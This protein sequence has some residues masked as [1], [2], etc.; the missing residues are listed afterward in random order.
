MSAY[1][2][3]DEFDLERRV[4]MT[5]EIPPYDMYTSLHSTM[6]NSFWEWI[7]GTVKVGYDYPYLVYDASSQSLIHNTDSE[8]VY[9]KMTNGQ[10]SSNYGPQTSTDTY[11]RLEIDGVLEPEFDLFLHEIYRYTETLYPDHPDERYLLTDTEFNDTILAAADMINYQP[12]VKFF[13][14]VAESLS[15]SLT[16]SEIKDEAAKLKIHNLLNEAFRRKLYGSKAGYRMLANDI[17]QMCT[18]FPV[19]TYL[20]LKEI[21]KERI[22]LE[23]KTA[24]SVDAL[25]TLNM[26]K[27]EYIKYVRQN[28][29][30]IDTYSSLYYRKFRLVD[31]DGQSSSYL[32]KED[33]NT[34][35]YGFSIPCEENRIFE[36][37]NSPNSSGSEIESVVTG[38]FFS[39][40]KDVKD[41]TYVNATSYNDT[42]ITEVR[43]NN[44]TDNG[45]TIYYGSESTSSTNAVNYI[46][47]SHLNWIQ[48]I[49][50]YIYDNVE[51][52]FNKFT[53]DSSLKTLADAYDGRYL[54]NT[55]L[56]DNNYF[57]LIFKNLATIDTDG[58]ILGNVT[59]D[60]LNVLLN[61]YADDT[62][63]LEPSKSMSFYP[64]DINIENPGT[65][66]KVRQDEIID[67]YNVFDKELCNSDIINNT[68]ET[69][70]YLYYIS[71]FTKGKISYSVSSIGGLFAKE[72]QFWGDARYGIVVNTKNN[73]KVVLLGKL[74]PKYGTSSGQLYI[75][76]ATIDITAI[77]E[78]KTDA[79]LVASYSDA[80]SNL[81]NIKDC[82]IAEEKYVSKGVGMTY[83]GCEDIIAL[84][85]S[86]TES[87]E[88]ERIYNDKV[89]E[90]AY[91]AIQRYINEVADSLEVHTKL[92]ITCDNKEY[93]FFKTSETNE[94]DENIIALG[95]K[96]VTELDKAVELYKK[97]SGKDY[98]ILISYY[99]SRKASEE[100]IETY[101]QNRSLMFETA[102]K[103]SDGSSYEIS[104]IQPGC[105]VSY[106]M[107]AYY[108][109]DAISYSDDVNFNEGIIDSF[110]LGCL[111]VFPLIN[112][113]VEV[114]KPYEFDADAAVNKQRVLNDDFCV[115]F[116]KKF[117]SSS[118]DIY[119]LKGYYYDHSINNH[120][121]S[122][123]YSGVDYVTLTNNNSLA[124]SIISGTY[125]STA[126]DA[127]DYFASYDGTT[128]DPTNIT[129]EPISTTNV[130]IEGVVDIETEGLERTVTF[131]SDLAKERC[132]SLSIGDTIYG[133]S[134]DTDDNDIYITSVGDNYVV[135][136]HD[137]QQS[138]TFVFTFK[139]KLNIVSE[140]ITDDILN[141]KE[142]L[143][144]NGLYSIINP[145]K[146]GL[147]GS[148]DFPNVS[149][150][151]LESLPDIIFYQPYNYITPL[152]LSSF[153]E[154]MHKIHPLY[155]EDND[156]SLPSTIKFNNDLFVELNLN[157]YMNQATKTSVSPSLITVDWL[158]Y[159]T[160]MLNTISRATDKVNIGIN[161]MMETDSTGYYTLD[162]DL[163]Y[164]D[165]NVR[166][167]FI[168]L[169]LDGMDMWNNYPIDT[170]ND[171]TVP[172]YAQIGTG[173]SGRATWF[174]SPADI[175]YPTIWGNSVYDS[176]NITNEDYENI[177]VNNGKLKRRSIWGKDS[178]ENKEYINDSRYSSVEK[179][180]FEIPLGEYDIQTRYLPT[181]TTDI[182]LASTTVQ[183][184]FFQETFNNLTKY[185]ED[186]DRDI[187]GQPIIVNKNDYINSDPIN[188]IS[189]FTSI[190]YLGEWV[191][192]KYIDDNGYYQIYYPIGK[193]NGDYY[194]INNNITLNDIGENLDSITFTDHTILLYENNK[195]TLYTFK[196]GSLYGNLN[197]ISNE[198]TIT[199]TY[200]NTTR[201]NLKLSFI[202]S[203]LYR[204]IEEFD[205]TDIL[206]IPVAAS[207]IQNF[208]F[209]KDKSNYLGN[210]ILW[211]INV[212]T[213]LYGTEIPL[214]LINNKEGQ[215]ENS[216]D[217]S[218]KEKITLNEGDIF[219][220]IIPADDYT[221]NENTYEYSFNNDL[222]IIKFNRCYFTNTLNIISN[223]II[224]DNE[225]SYLY[226]GKYSTLTGESNNLSNGLTKITLPRKF[227]TNGSY[228]F[229][230][231]I[232]PQFTA[233]GYEYT[234]SESNAVGEEGYDIIEN[235]NFDIVDKSHEV[236]FNVTR[237]AIYKDE[238]NDEFYVYTDTIDGE[239][240]DTSEKLKKVAIKFAEQKYFKNTIYITGA[241]QV[242]EDMQS[243]DESVTKN[244]YMNAIAGITEFQASYLAANDRILKI[245]PMSLRSIYNRYLESIFFSN[246]KNYDAEILGI[247]QN[248]NLVLSYDHDGDDATF[249][250]MNFALN[251]KQYAPANKYFDS[252]SEKYVTEA[253]NDTYYNFTDN[254]KFIAPTVRFNKV[255]KSMFADN[256]AEDE[257]TEFKYFKNLLMARVTVSLTN[258]NVIYQADNDSGQFQTLIK[259]IRTGDT[260]QDGITI[261][262]DIDKETLSQIDLINAQTSSPV[263]VSYVAYDEESK[264]FMAI[265]N[266]G[267][268]Y[269][270]SNV[271]LS[272]ASQV[273]LTE[274]FIDGLGTGSSTGYKTDGLSIDKSDSTNPIW[275]I[276][277]TDENNTNSM[278]Y[279]IPFNYSLNS[280]GH[281]TAN[282]LFGEQQNLNG[283]S[284]S[285]SDIINIGSYTSL[286]FD[287]ND[288]TSPGVAT[289]NKYVLAKDYAISEITGSAGN[290][291]YKNKPYINTDYSKFDSLPQTF[292]AK[293]T[294]SE[295]AVFVSDR[296]I[297]IRSP[298]YYCDASGNYTSDVSTEFF[299]KKTTAPITRDGLQGLILNK[300]RGYGES[301]GYDYVYTRW[302][303]FYTNW[304]FLFS[305]DLTADANKNLESAITNP[306]GGF[307]TE[308]NL[309]SNIDEGTYIAWKDDII[310]TLGTN[311]TYSYVKQLQALIKRA[312]AILPVSWTKIKSA[313]ISAKSHLNT[314]YYIYATY[315][316]STVTETVSNSTPS[317][318]DYLS[319]TYNGSQYNIN[320]YG[321]GKLASTSYVNL[322]D[323][324]VEVPL[325]YNVNA[326]MSKTTP[327]ASWSTTS[328][329]DSDWYAE[330]LYLLDSYAY[331]DV[332]F[333][334]LFKEKIYRVLFTDDSI[335]F[336][337]NDWSIITL[338][339]SDTYKVETINDIDNWNVVG[340]N[341]YYSYT[342]PDF[343]GTKM[344]IYKT[345]KYGTGTNDEMSVKVISINEHPKIF[346]IEATYCDSSVMILG[347][348]LKSISTIEHEYET[349][350]G[351]ELSEEGYQNKLKDNKYY[352]FFENSIYP[353]VMYSIDNGVTFNISVID[354]ELPNCSLVKDGNKQ[355]Y[356]SANQYRAAYKEP[357]NG[358]GAKVSGIHYVDGK[359]KLHL[360]DGDGNEFGYQLYPKENS[361]TGSLEWSTLEYEEVDTTE[362][363]VTSSY[364]ELYSNFEL[365]IFSNSTYVNRAS[366][367]GLN[368]GDNSVTKC[369]DNAITMSR[370][371][372]NKQTSGGSIQ[373]LVTFKTG[374]SISLAT[375][376][377]VI[378]KFSLSEYMDVGVPKLEIIT[379]VDNYST[380][381][382]MYNYRETLTDIERKNIST[383]YR[384][385][386]EDT[387]HTY[388]KYS[389]ASDS[390]GNLSY[391]L[392]E[393]KNS[394]NNNINLCDIDGN[395]IYNSG[396]ELYTYD[397]DD[398]LASS[399]DPNVLP[400]AGQTT[401]PSVEAAENDSSL[402][403]EDTDFKAF[404][405]TT[406]NEMNFTNT[407][408]NYF[409]IFGLD[410]KVSIKSGDYITSTPITVNGVE[411][412]ELEVKSSISSE[413]TLVSEKETDSITSLP[414]FD[415]SKK[416][417]VKYTG[418]ERIL[419]DPSVKIGISSISDYT[420]YLYSESD[421]DELKAIL[422]STDDIQTMIPYR[423]FETRF[424][425]VKINGTNYFYDKKMGVLPF[426][427]RR[428]IN[429]DIYTDYALESEQAIYTN[430]G[431]NE[432]TNSSAFRSP[433]TGI[434]IPQNGYG[435]LRGRTESNNSWSDELPWDLDPIAFENSYLKNAVGDY[436]KICNNA[437]IALDSNNGETL[438]TKSNTYEIYYKDILPGKSKTIKIYKFNNNNENDISSIS[439]Y[440]PIKATGKIWSS[441]DT[442]YINYNLASGE[443]QKLANIKFVIPS[444][445]R[446]ED[447]AEYTI[448]VSIDGKNY[449]NFVDDN[450]DNILSIKNGILLYTTPESTIDRPNY[451]KI[452][453][454]ENNFTATKVLSVVSSSIENIIYTKI[455]PIWYYNSNDELKTILKKATLQL[456]DTSINTF[457]D[458]SIYA[459]NS[460]TFVNGKK[461][462]SYNDSVSITVNNIEYTLNL[463]IFD[464]GTTKT[465]VFTDYA[466]SKYIIRSF[467]D[468]YEITS[469]TY[470]ASSYNS[471]SK[472]YTTKM[473]TI[474]MSTATKTYNVLYNNNGISFTVDSIN[475]S[476]NTTKPDIYLSLESG[477]TFI[478]IE[479]DLYSKDEDKI[480]II[481]NGNFSNIDT[482][483]AF[484]KG[485]ISPILMRTPTY[486]DLNNLIN[487]NGYVVSNYD[488]YFDY[489][490]G[491]STDITFN[492]I[493]TNKVTFTSPF[494]I[495]D[496]N[497][498]NIHYL[499]IEVLTQSSV[500]TNRL[501]CNDTN[502]YIELDNSELE[503]FPPD[504]VYFADNG[505]PKS[506]IMIDNIVYRSENNIYYT[507][508]SFVN[509]NG[510]YVRECNS[511]GELIRYYISGGNLANRVLTATDE[512]STTFVP[513]RPN[514]MTCKKW[515]EG[516]FYIKG[517]ESNPFWQFINLKPKF[518]SISQEW[519]QVAT[520]NKYSKVGTTMKT[521]EVPEG[522]RYVTIYKG[523]K[524]EYIDDTIIQAYNTDYLDLT[525]GILRFIFTQPDDIY[526]TSENL[527]EYGI[528]VENSFYNDN[529]DSSKIMTGYLQSSYTVN[530]KKNFANPADSDSSIVEV[531]EFGLFNKSHQL[532]AYAVFPP[533]EYR[534]DS[535][536]ISFTS[537][538]KYGSCTVE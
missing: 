449:E 252:E 503:T 115:K 393:L 141:Y 417:Y 497:D 391:V 264:E 68:N 3:S 245:T 318:E 80:R 382:R 313:I 197:V 294:R 349:A 471:K 326:V 235:D 462:E 295:Y 11:N 133:P 360:S 254:D 330:Y 299:W 498:G 187:T 134:L 454:T 76:G 186:T 122:T 437:G 376:M 430:R 97:F 27:D 362:S 216:V 415:T 119:Y 164:T 67:K 363:T 113:R 529:F 502:Y 469:Y 392:K 467:I 253:Y 192:E 75:A 64:T 44:Y 412:I 99:I 55:I 483:P 241:Y 166:L 531:T 194:I 219:G 145:F 238:A 278:V 42:Y 328:S 207:F 242:E 56:A 306:D 350:Y 10:I 429:I 71:N 96:D 81:T 338:K 65:D 433:I 165:P 233:T 312:K 405:K 421:E 149:N 319:I 260:I 342:V 36:Y 453:C 426:K 263:T 175:T 434:Y 370:P 491:D 48:Y 209:E 123:V 173:G 311:L 247:D 248:N 298:N 455:E 372:A 82:K 475:L 410:G 86:D 125:N 321:I 406:L 535:Q 196:C 369:S 225:I 143:D 411:D 489:S 343:A 151:I 102:T 160:S 1:T 537:F 441:S 271:N 93:Y 464:I 195:W 30:E 218:D 150:A 534:T 198:D 505:Y 251:L 323:E 487:A 379:E 407:S 409:D 351:D 422:G 236:T 171:W 163:L 47:T 54:K 121:R 304:D 291:T 366:Y 62:L 463:P 124:Y 520:L 356:N 519:S 373:V 177:T 202:E 220:I 183:S 28:K 355:I 138:G 16:D 262:G 213:N 40:S 106:I 89:K 137:L 63:L 43:L 118:V 404:D 381:D 307:S 214:Y 140:D 117:K 399:F 300:V 184:S 504:R 395:I 353:F 329:S 60:K 274:I 511:N 104:T 452:T 327:T 401:Y 383:G 128:E 384:A 465:Y 79:Q 507:K 201:S 203:L 250:K 386:S 287:D 495:D 352:T 90:T 425:K 114:I 230:Y 205:G 341:D 461:S 211:F 348:Y 217:A 420:D 413:Y 172:A 490:N 228:N 272:T 222:H 154:V 39:N 234:S 419:A 368:L 435:G 494:D 390:D 126:I 364:E 293:D 325:Y 255:T 9:L 77:P 152:G 157:R 277:V 527:M 317:V 129:C 231:I 280:N 414:V 12:N 532:I 418:E 158:D 162:K 514:Y 31:W 239:K 70:D 476:K 181:N 485:T 116:T 24:N 135:L 481:T 22:E 378:N 354:T 521:V 408:I 204:L 324:T 347:G 385:T 431:F 536:H 229:N 423:T 442:V 334:N 458:Y 445:F 488:P 153:N 478:A 340:T 84:Y 270:A 21:S 148:N 279:S 259:Y 200:G 189:G 168:T 142:T 17:F 74:T 470:D 46:E 285:D 110:S 120:P 208:L 127:Q 100:K 332:D 101:R 518:N 91:Q 396:E 144:N 533:I 191:P 513:L 428:Y 267:T 221:Y 147:Y 246:Y 308:P 492:E 275:V 460:F 346:N 223:G 506:P 403:L 468:D 95:I 18:I 320:H 136:N 269:F 374:T 397:L 526:R 266:A 333:E 78:T 402:R 53:T 258:P 34:Y 161:L 466:N 472:K 112:E 257:V 496:I 4:W 480:N 174:T 193:N 130:Q 256:K 92:K 52:Y 26:S 305:I 286:K 108:S 510:S 388:Y 309:P 359:Y 371:L 131:T 282:G 226:S 297:F 224:T 457:D 331:L 365:F 13:D 292:Y 35:F 237:G 398:L 459:D 447:K 139:C 474:S 206:T 185:M 58:S 337:C 361:N 525:D 500:P 179:P 15:V 380:A 268:G 29:R 281:I 427:K 210:T 155:D 19:A 66:F 301:S 8:D 94:N 244:A 538:I 51:D 516:Q 509:D 451:I 37:P 88:I 227:I 446:F 512:L 499:R 6:H 302:Q 2:S 188:S 289:T 73:D 387:D 215:A 182:S 132:K 107:S 50:M 57:E 394:G 439:I 159:L 167:K 109:D 72:L 344:P 508:S 358:T 45:K 345:I 339:K 528:Y 477:S 440:K 530:S 83:E 146:H 456:S 14:K 389:T 284:V 33:P 5:N 432:V 484:I 479:N 444:Q 482:S 473:N 336:I 85:T 178:Y 41:I 290:Y 303:G 438:C 261:R 524:A 416:Q 501:T 232:D 25:N 424:T 180:L 105:T 335:I 367:T 49:P 98:S 240:I 176:P 315:N 322:N 111:N 212:G 448:K 7:I 517:Q 493:E 296:D 314:T 522:E 69:A 87:Y 443:V 61:P 243:G 103:T 32:Q 436:I 283:I 377:E 515:F 190:S 23:Q 316:G 523:S 400:V 357:A 199:L 169:N 156:Y 265:N 170:A 38:S 375:Q 310:N 486:V 450:D 273:K 288:P 249:N 20:P 59:L 276:S